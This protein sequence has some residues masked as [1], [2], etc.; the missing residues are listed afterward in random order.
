MPTMTMLC[1]T[2]TAMA[3]TTVAA[4]VVK[5]SIWAENQA[6]LHDWSEGWDEA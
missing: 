5:W 4:A 2:L 6:S 3:L 1:I